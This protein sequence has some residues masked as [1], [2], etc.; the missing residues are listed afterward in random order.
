MIIQRNKQQKVTDGQLIKAARWMLN[1]QF[2]LR[3][4]DLRGQM[5][6]ILVAECRHVRPIK[7]DKVG[8]VN[9]TNERVLRVS[10]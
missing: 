8:R 9:Y 7:G 5:F 4:E 1:E 6:D 2:G 10:I 3:A